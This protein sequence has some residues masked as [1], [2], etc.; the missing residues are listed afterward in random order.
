MLRINYLTLSAFFSIICHLIFIQFFETY[1]QKDEEIIVM[2][3]TL[4]KEFKV[5]K[6]LS[7]PPPTQKEEKI[8]EKKLPQKEEKIIEKKLQKMEE[9]KIV[10]EKPKIEEKPKTQAKQKKEKI[11]PKKFEIQDPPDKTQQDQKAQQVITSKINAELLSKQLSIYL[12]KI[13]KEI[14][15]IAA[16]S[17]PRQSI[18]RREQGTIIATITLN[19]DGNLRNID[20]DKKKPKRLFKTTE[21]IFKKYVFP[22]PPENILNNQKLVKFKISVNFIL[23]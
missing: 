6:K 4:F 2:D 16:K 9:E 13:S 23:K 19:K 8:I 15:L 10:L 14:N 7:P 21:K 17:Y 22:K 20:F 18:K 11:K 5:E 3:L 1:K 12:G